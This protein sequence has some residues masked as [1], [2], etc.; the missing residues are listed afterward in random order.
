M[1]QRHAIATAGALMIVAALASYVAGLYVGR[2]QGQAGAAAALASVQANLGIN[3]LQ[4]S[5]ELESDLQRG[6]SKE[7]LAKLGYDIDSQLFVLASLYR[8]YKG[9]WVA[10]EIA[11]RDAQLPA[12]LEGFKKQFGEAWKEPRC[13]AQ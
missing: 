2:I 11:K 7:A 12:Q 9:A 4:R 1:N 13:A 5:R 6:C 3:N 8:Q 10:D